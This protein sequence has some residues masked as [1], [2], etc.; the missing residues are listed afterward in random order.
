MESEL[1]DWVHVMRYNTVTS[2]VE[3]YV[4]RLKCGQLFTFAQVMDRVDAE[5][6]TVSQAL[7]KLA[8]HDKLISVRKGLYLKPKRSKFGNVL[9]APGDVV[10]FVAKSKKVSIYPTGTTLLN[11]L[12]IS[13]QMP[14]GNTYISSKRIEPFAINNVKIHFK[15]SKAFEKMEKSFSPLNTKDRDI[16]LK[17]WIMLDYMGKEETY[18][19]SSR[20]KDYMNNFSYCGKTKFFNTLNG[21]LNWAHSLLMD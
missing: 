3:S 9:P 10:K 4:D 17:L 15:Y 2:N 1:N 20:L 21:K 11:A 14:M 19:A 13:T 16:A 7:R 18:H 6:D 8:D 12:G 5:K